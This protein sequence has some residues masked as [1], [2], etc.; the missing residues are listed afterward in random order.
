MKKIVFLLLSFLMLSSCYDKD[1]DPIGLKK[2][3]LNFGFVGGRI[4]VGTKGDVFY[5]ENRKITS[6]TVISPTLDT[7]RD[8]W[9]EVV[10]LE[11]EQIIKVFAKPN[12]TQKIREFAFSIVGKGWYYDT[13]KI[14]Q[15]GNP[16]AEK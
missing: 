16:D 7:L 8:E 11:S 2:K 1:I 3:E 14:T 9:I 4:D 13:I 6:K 12:D 15:K 5:I 10:A